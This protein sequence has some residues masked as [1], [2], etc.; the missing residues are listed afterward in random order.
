MTNLAIFTYGVI[1]YLQCLLGLVLTTGVL[2]VDINY[3][4]SM[5]TCMH[6]LITMIGEFATFHLIP[7]KTAQDHRIDKQK[8]LEQGLTNRILS[9]LTTEL[10]D[11]PKH[12]STSK[13][14]M[15]NQLHRY[16]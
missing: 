4:T 16:F 15:R 14:R 6:L 9:Y 11:K 12:G 13:S 1:L 2:C 8:Y 10:T 7:G 3:G 5:D